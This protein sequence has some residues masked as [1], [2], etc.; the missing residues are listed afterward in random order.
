[1]ET[2]R[3]FRE[4]FPSIHESAYFATC[5]LGAY[6]IGLEEAIGQMLA[7]MREPALAWGAFE[8]GVSALR[9]SVGSF[10]GT[11]ADRVAIVPNA[12]IGA[13]QVATSIDW[14]KRPKIVTCAAEFPSIT[15][16]WRAQAVRGAITSV[17]PDDTS[18]EMLTANYLA[19][20]DQYTGLVSIPACGY[21][22]GQRFPV[23][24]IAEAAHRAGSQ[25]FVDA[26]QL[27]GA[28][29]MAP[30]TAVADHMVF[31]FSKYLLGLPGAAVLYSADPEPEGPAP[32]L[33]GWMGAPDPF[34]R[35]AAL[36]TYSD[37]ARRYETGTPAIPAVYAAI[38]GLRLLERIP[39][40][41]IRDHIRTLTEAAASSL[42][43]AGYQVCSPRSPHQRGPM[44]AVR[45]P[46]AH[47]LAEALQQQRIV[48]S[49]RADTV[50]FAFHYYNT[51]DDIDRLAAALQ[52]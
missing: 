6:S 34:G 10:L 33:T 44:I 14:R 38:S 39:A 25:V 18:I 45:H 3:E 40:T 13:Y 32:V 31:G 35:D 28:E 2:S 17:I 41:A 9:R 47:A 43:G 52:D 26:F 7:E 23:R 49:P 5:S 20:I 30:I 27:V 4:H 11:D 48:T 50:R 16:I 46:N 1:M 51:S 24:E 19:S 15:R 21:L 29:P 22:Y 12:T 42:Y 37:T 36:L 8:R